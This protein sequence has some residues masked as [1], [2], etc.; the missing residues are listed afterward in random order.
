MHEELIKHIRSIKMRLTIGV[1]TTRNETD[2]LL[3]NQLDAMEEIVNK[4]LALPLV[5]VELPELCSQCFRRNTQNREI[6]KCGK[7]FKGN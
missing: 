1:I 7:P 5:S 6:C 4:N 3:M 2:H